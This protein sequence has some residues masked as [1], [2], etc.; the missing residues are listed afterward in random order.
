MLEGLKSSIVG[1][2]FSNFMRDEAM[3]MSAALAFYTALSLAP[4]LIIV[5]YLSRLLGVEVRGILTQQIRELV[6]A[7]AADVVTI[8]IQ[9]AGRHTFAGTVS[10][11]VG[12]AA[13]LFSATAVFA[14]LQK[15]MNRIWGVRAEPGRGMQNYIR[16][17][18]LSLGMLVG[19]GFLLLVSLA[20]TTALNLFIS[21]EGVHWQ[22]ANFLGSL[23]VYVMLFALIFKVMPDV[24]LAWSSLILGASMTA[25]LFDI[26]K[27]AVG[28]YLSYRSIGS[29]YGA[30]GSLLVL[31]VWVYYSAIIV[32]FGAE[33]TEVYTR[34]YG[35]PPALKPHAVWAR[36][37]RKNTGSDLEN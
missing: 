24:R 28:R 3:M 23:L 13:L 29:V 1:R 6:G 25:V 27:F 2:A 17:R 9:A 20:V 10:T 14:Q 15:A 5:T 35:T 11:A 22:V 18:L 30:A 34:R 36:R 32:F 19:I 7:Q 21:G 16:K 26:G 33:I 12:I 31:L 4:L 8:V 37:P